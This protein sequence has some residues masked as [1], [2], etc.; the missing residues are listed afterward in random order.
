NRPI[1]SPHFLHEDPLEVGD[2][3][4]K[5]VVLTIRVAEQIQEE[6]VAQ[7]VLEGPAV[8][9]NIIA[10]RRYRQVSPWPLRGGE[11]RGEWSWGVPPHLPPHREVVE[12]ERA[13]PLVE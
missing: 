3:Q 5:V 1:A 10:A 4:R 12:S 11:G 8:W 6:L 2:E 7:H 13:R 9:P